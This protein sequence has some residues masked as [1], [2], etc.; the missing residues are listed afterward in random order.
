MSYV[1]IEP[2][3]CRWH[4]FLNWIDF[5]YWRC[6]CYHTCEWGGFV[7]EGGCKYHD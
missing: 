3:C 4:A 1:W 2:Q 7:I 5:R 6:E